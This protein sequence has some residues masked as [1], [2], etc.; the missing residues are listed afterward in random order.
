MGGLAMLLIVDDDPAVKSAMER[1]LQLRGFEPDTAAD[2]AEAV[3]K[4]RCSPYK[5]VIMDIEMPKMN[6]IEAIR[7]IKQNH[8]GMPIIILTGFVHDVE[9]LHDV[10][11]EGILAKPI[12]MLELETA[13]RGVIER[14]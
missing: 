6:G 13:I 3:E 1:W 14:A 4:C 7:A 8:P 12:R 9:K 5:I 2:G 11:V 10:A